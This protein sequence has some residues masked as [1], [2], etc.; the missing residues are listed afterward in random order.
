MAVKVINSEPDPSVIKHAIC[1]NRGAKLEYVPA[2]VQSEQHYDYGGGR[3]TYYFI[4]CP[5]CSNK[6]SAKN[7]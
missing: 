5:Q 6:V 1:R 7:Y 3:D 2:D 4:V